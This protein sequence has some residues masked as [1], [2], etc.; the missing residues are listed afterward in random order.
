M[1]TTKLSDAASSRRV[2]G[3]RLFGS[4]MIQPFVC[5]SFVCLFLASSR[6]PSVLAYRSLRLSPANAFQQEAN[7]LLPGATVERE[8]KGGEVHN[9]RISLVRGQ[10]M[11]ALVRQIGIDVV[12]TT[13]G[14]EGKRLFN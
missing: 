6:V 2:S 8:L 14:P 7:T 1:F 5:L 3:K 11:H 10:F 13:F 12:V 4:R 9:F